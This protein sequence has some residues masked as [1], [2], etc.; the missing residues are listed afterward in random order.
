MDIEDAEENS[1]IR[2][3]KLVPAY[4]LTEQYSL[5]NPVGEF[6]LI[7]VEETNL[8]NSAVPDPRRVDQTHV[9]YYT[10]EL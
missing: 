4:P 8:A 3:I 6:Y 2:G 5:E 9:L 10:D 7:P 1:I